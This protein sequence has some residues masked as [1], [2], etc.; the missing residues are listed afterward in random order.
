M[1]YVTS[2]N[3]AI[4]MF[5]FVALLFTMP[6]ILNQYHKYG[7]ISFFKSII[8]YLFIFYLI[9]AYFL[10]ILP[11]PKI[12]E[13]ALMTTPE[14]QLIPF[15]F[16]IDFINDFPEFLE[17][18]HNYLLII[19]EP[20]FY[21]PIFNIIL[22]IPFGMFLRYYFKYSLKKVFVS[23]FLLSLFF[24]LTQLSGL[25]FIYPRSYRLFDVDDLM[26]NTLGGVVGFYLAQV[27]MKFL[28]KIDDVNKN[29]L[30]KGKYI[31]V[32]RRTVATSLDL[33]ILLIIE[34]L[35]IVLW[36]DNIYLALIIA[37]IYYFIIP[38]FLNSSTLAQKFLNIAVYDYNNKMNVGRLF[39]RKILLILIYIIIPFSTFS[40]IL[41]INNDYIREFSGIIILLGIFLIYFITG[42]KY[43]FTGKDMMYEKFSKTKLVSTIDKIKKD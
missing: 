13:V 18:T 27:F 20:Y 15:E 21:I 38:L 26:L 30:E 10:V 9:C 7:S 39:L 42:I 36:K 28:P 23:T 35:F 14:V 19:K 33:F 40:F 24:E 3:Y 31:S 25:Y 43:I 12:S 22:T 5:P 4:L 29:A 16:V 41:D 8:I 37:F 34:L 6:F 2:I 17:N 11:L 32:F 1:G